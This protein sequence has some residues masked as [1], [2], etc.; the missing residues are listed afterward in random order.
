MRQAFVRI[1]LIGRCVPKHC[2]L[3]ACREV[4]SVNMIRM[5]RMNGRGRG[6]LLVHS[7]MCIPSPARQEHRAEDKEQAKPGKHVPKLG[8]NYI[9]GNMLFPAG[10]LRCQLAGSIL[11]YRIPTKIWR[12]G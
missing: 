11:D 1:P 9:R 2:L 7:Q 8:L 10:L 12:L 3:K 6:Q 4:H 5:V